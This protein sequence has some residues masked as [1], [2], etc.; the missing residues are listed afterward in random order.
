MLDLRNLH[1]HPRAHI[2][3]INFVCIL[4]TMGDGPWYE[5]EPNAIVEIWIECPGR[6]ASA[7]NDRQI[8]ER[9][10]EIILDDSGA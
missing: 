6:R 1:G 9:H 3:A 4:L 2:V 5:S 10:G 7:R 8:S